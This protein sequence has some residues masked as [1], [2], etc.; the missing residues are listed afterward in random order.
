MAGRR[1]VLRRLALLLPAGHRLRRPDRHH[2][3]S[4][5]RPDRPSGKAPSTKDIMVAV[6]LRPSVA[7]VFPAGVDR[8]RAARLPV[9]LEPDRTLGRRRT[10]AGRVGRRV[11]VEVGESSLPPVFA[12]AKVVVTTASAAIAVHDFVDLPVQGVQVVLLVKV[13]ILHVLLEEKWWEGARISRTTRTLTG[14]TRSGS[15]WIENRISIETCRRGGVTRCVQRLGN[16]SRAE[17]CTRRILDVASRHGN[18]TA[19]GGKVGIGG[20]QFSL[21]LLLAET[22]QDSILAMAD[23]APVSVG[24][25]SWRE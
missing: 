16:A 6:V 9:V 8:L 17:R 20:G 11:G 1:R 12:F 10:E 19:V 23:T 7:Q 13:S 15:G 22:T 25:V 21:S 3:R 2:G 18:L 4:V 5:L 24:T 14:R